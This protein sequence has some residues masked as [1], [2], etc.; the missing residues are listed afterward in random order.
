MYEIAVEDGQ[1]DTAAVLA[2]LALA[3]SEHS[4]VI[5]NITVRTAAGEPGRY[6]AFL[7]PLEPAPSSAFA[8]LPVENVTTDGATAA[9]MQQ[10]L[11]NV[12]RTVDV[13]SLSRTLAMTRREADPPEL[14]QLTTRELDVVTRLLS[15]DGFRQSRSRCGSARARCETT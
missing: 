9:A 15:G 11:S 10:L 12:R 7:M 4:A 14:S 6:E 5:V 2:S 13:A 1:N 3:F 8:L